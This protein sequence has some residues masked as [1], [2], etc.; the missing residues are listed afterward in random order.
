LPES[1]IFDG[2]IGDELTV[3]C[4]PAPIKQKNYKCSNKFFLDPLVPLYQKGEIM[5][6]AIVRGEKLELTRIR[7]Y[8]NNILDYKQLL[9]LSTHI[10]NRHRK[11]GQS[12]ARFGRIRNSQIIDFVSDSAERIGMIFKHEKHIV[13]AGV[14]NKKNQVFQLL[15]KNIKK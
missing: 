10:N 14:G 15:D 13:I 12:S 2:N 11:G 5:G 7:V 8:E 6:L 1:G 9:G 3:L 4:P